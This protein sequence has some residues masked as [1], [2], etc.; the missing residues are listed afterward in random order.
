MDR[1]TTGIH[2]CSTCTWNAGGWWEA[3][4]SQSVGYRSETKVCHS[5]EPVGLFELG[6]VLPSPLGH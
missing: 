4:V 5:S 2:L 3:V 1:I 6:I